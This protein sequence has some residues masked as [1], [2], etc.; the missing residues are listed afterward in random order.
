VPA[1]KK[2][3]LLNLRC[4]APITKNPKLQDTVFKE[5]MPILT[6]VILLPAVV[7]QTVKACNQPVQCTGGQITHRCTVTEYC[8]SDTVADPAL[9][10]V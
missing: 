6:V 7:L 1:I 8:P 10:V 5:N 3:K 4:L 9:V 2:R